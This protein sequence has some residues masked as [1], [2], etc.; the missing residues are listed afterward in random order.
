MT[1][2]KL[3]AVAKQAAQGWKELQKMY[4]GQDREHKEHGEIGS[5]HRDAFEAWLDDLVQNAE[6]ALTKEPTA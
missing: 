5:H 3:A 1:N 4:D 6:D 2:E